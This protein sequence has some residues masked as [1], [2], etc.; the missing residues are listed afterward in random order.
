MLGCARDRFIVALIERQEPGSVLQTGGWDGELLRAVSTAL[1]ARG[2][3]TLT[4]L[5]ANPARHA[6]LRKQIGRQALRNTTLLRLDG[7]DLV[8]ENRYDFVIFNGAYTDPIGQNPE[9]EC[10]HV[11]PCLKDGA[12]VVFTD[13]E[14]ET[15][16][17]DNLPKKLEAMSVLRGRF[18]DTT[19]GLY[20]GNYDSPKP[21]A[22]RRMV[23]CASAGRSGTAFLTTLLSGAPGLVALHEPKPWYNGETLALQDDPSHARHFV[24][25]VK[26]PWIQALPGHTYVELSHYV[27]KGFLEAWLDLGIRPDVIV[28]KREP[29]RIA[30][31][32]FAMGIDFFERPQTPRQHMLHPDDRRP[33]HLRVPDWRAFNNYQ[34]CYWYALETERRIAH[35]LKLLT[36]HF[37]AQVFATS[38]EQLSA[39]IDE[40]KRLYS[41]LNVS[42]D[43][44]D[45]RVLGGRQARK[46]NELTAKKYADRLESIKTLDLDALEAELLTATCAPGS[47]EEIRLMPDGTFAE[48]EK[49]LAEAR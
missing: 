28:L 9:A 1:A 13:C 30:L 29:R 42:L 11:V 14:R 36:E 33:L 43:E 26:W 32:R 16:S 37:S 49:R 34:L 7:Q 4:V 6:E 24:E 31:S 17:L 46:I 12:T 5:E 44:E 23:F 35:Y 18:V 39:E 41:W 47:N 22:D 2:Q 21:S 3:A 40:V 25:Q 10:F 27:M 20:V 48:H 19:E 45:V 15:P 38:L 8:T